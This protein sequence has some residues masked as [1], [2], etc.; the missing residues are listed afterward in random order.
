MAVAQLLTNRFVVALVVPLLLF[1]AGGFGKK[2]VRSEKNWHRK[3][4]YLGVDAALAAFSAALIYLFDVAGWFALTPSFDPRLQVYTRQ[5]AAT[6][7]FL[8]LAFFL[9]LFVL[10][11]HQNWEASD[12]NSSAQ[13]F[14]LIGVSNLIGLG[15]MFLFVL[16]V[17]GVT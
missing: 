9:F 7:V 2:L 12:N 13:W 15:L 4:W 11:V 14:W 3:D 10:G 1:L 8:A 5:L 6:G 17:K 16:A